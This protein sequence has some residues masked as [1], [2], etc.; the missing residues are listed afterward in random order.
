MVNTVN[1]AYLGLIEGIA[2][3][4]IRRVRAI[5]V[6]RPESMDREIR[7]WFSALRVA[8]SIGRVAIGSRPLLMNA[9]QMRENRENQYRQLMVFQVELKVKKKTNF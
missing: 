3:I 5:V 9:L 1:S 4:A 6:V 2:G 7:G 8:A